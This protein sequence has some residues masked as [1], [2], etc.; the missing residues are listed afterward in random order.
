[1]TQIQNPKPVY[2]LDFISKFWS[3]IIGIWDLFVI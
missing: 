1:M 2:D 3:L